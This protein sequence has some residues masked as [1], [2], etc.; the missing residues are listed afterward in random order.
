MKTQ[1]T[2]K[3]TELNPLGEIHHEQIE[4]QP[5]KLDAWATKLGIPKQQ[6]R[7]LAAEVGPVFADIQRRW[8]EMIAERLAADDVKKEQRGE[9]SIAFA[10]RDVLE[11]LRSAAGR[12]TSIHDED[13]AK[14]STRELVRRF[15]SH[16]QAAG[17]ELALFASG[18]LMQPGFRG[19][20]RCHQAAVDL[21]HVPEGA[22]R[23]EASLL[24][25]A[26]LLHDERCRRY[27]TREHTAFVAA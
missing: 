15:L 6:V 1:T 22:D 13:P 14:I 19:E 12:P 10:R 2:S 4:S 5:W 17:F 11:W 7:Q 27:L 25:C 8:E 9:E 21:P 3:S 20:W 18:S 26:A 24:A 23:E 16:A